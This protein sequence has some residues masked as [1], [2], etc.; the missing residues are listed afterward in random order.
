MRLTYLRQ[1][2]LNGLKSS[3]DAASPDGIVISTGRALLS[4]IPITGPKTESPADHEGSASIDIT[5]IRKRCWS[6]LNGP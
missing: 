5:P 3:A 4:P 6:V 1:A 2:A